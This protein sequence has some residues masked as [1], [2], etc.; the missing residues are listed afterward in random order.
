MVQVLRQAL[1]SLSTR[2]GQ[3]AVTALCA[4]WQIEANGKR[5]PRPLFQ[6]IEWRQ[7]WENNGIRLSITWETIGEL[8]GHSWRGS[9]LVEC[10]NSLLRPGL[11]SCQHTDQGCLDLFHFSHNEYSSKRGKRKGHN[12]AQLVG[13][14]AVDD[15]HILLA[16]APKVSI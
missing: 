5:H 10:V 14:D 4:F 12:P 9:I 15:P 13:L 1:S 2:Y 7:L 8:L 11:D 3:E 16:L 6:R